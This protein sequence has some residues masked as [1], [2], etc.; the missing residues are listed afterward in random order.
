MVKLEFY[1]ETQ[2]VSTTIGV[3]MAAKKTKTLMNGYSYQDLFD[4]QSG[5]DTGAYDQVLSA[6]TNPSGGIAGFARLDS[7]NLGSILGQADSIAAFKKR[8]SEQQRAINSGVGTQQ[9]ILG[10]GAF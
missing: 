3:S 9:S 5:L 1:L 7:S 2:T 10:G 6:E 4:A 8:K